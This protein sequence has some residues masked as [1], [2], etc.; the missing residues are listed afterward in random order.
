MKSLFRFLAVLFLLALAGCSTISSAFKSNEQN[1]ASLAG[2]VTGPGCAKVASTMQPGECQPI[3]A[4]LNAC[5]NAFM[6]C[7]SKPTPLPTAPPI[8]KP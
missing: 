7:A 3:S 2:S 6:L 4:G 5:T 8:P 1:L